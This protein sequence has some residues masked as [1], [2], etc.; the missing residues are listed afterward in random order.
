MGYPCFT[1]IGNKMNPFAWLSEKL[2]NDAQ[3]ATVTFRLKFDT[4]RRIKFH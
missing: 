3:D 1:G 2:S 4:I